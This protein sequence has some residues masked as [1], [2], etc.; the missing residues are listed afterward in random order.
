MHSHQ[1]TFLLAPFEHREVD[2]PKANKLILITQPQLS[3]HFQ[4]KL[5]KLFTCFHHIVAGQDQNQ[6]TRFSTECLFHLLQ[7]FLRIE[8]IHARFYSSVRFYTGIHHTF[9]TNLRFLYE[10]RQCIQLLTSISCST[11]GTDTTHISSI[12]EH[13][14]SV[15]F[16]DIHQFHEF[17]AETQVRFVTTIIFH[18]IRPRHTLERFS[19]FHTTQCFEQMFSHSFESSDNIFLLNEAHFAVNL[20]KFRLTVSTQVLI[21]ETFCDLEVTVETGNHQQLLQC[22]RRLRKCVELSRIHT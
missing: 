18:G 20:R 17:H 5:T 14:E 11:F 13:R 6:V 4:T 1:T 22:L 10:V 2:H 12:I 7:H 8:F 15:T 16:H 19:Q 21:A 9:C 3:A